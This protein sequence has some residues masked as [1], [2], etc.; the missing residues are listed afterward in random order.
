MVSGHLGVSTPSKDNVE[1]PDCN[2]NGARCGLALG[3]SSYVPGGGGEM[4][5]SEALRAKRS[6]ETSPRKSA[7]AF[8]RKGL[9]NDFIPNKL[10]L[11]ACSVSFGT[12]C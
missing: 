8:G 7:K 10:F 1:T 9:T 5:S 6:L 11:A 2:V 12:A 4:R 3:A